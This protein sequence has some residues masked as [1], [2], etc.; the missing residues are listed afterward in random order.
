[1]ISALRHTVRMAVDLP[2][3]LLEDL[4]ALAA[5][6]ATVHADVCTVHD[7]EF[8][9]D[10]GCTCGFPRLLRSLAEHLPLPAGASQPYR[11]AWVPTARAA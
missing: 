3:P 5:I 7:P 1:L 9:G 10:Y 4:H 8:P 6:S 2:V 11:P